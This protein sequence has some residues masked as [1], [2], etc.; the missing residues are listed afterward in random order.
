MNRYLSLLRPLIAV[1]ILAGLV[2]TV[3]FT[4]EKPVRYYW[5]DVAHVDSLRTILNQS[6]P[7]WMRLQERPKGSGHW[8]MQVNPVDTTAARLMALPEVEE[9]FPCPPNCR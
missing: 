6:G 9:S 3:A 2:L 8:W 5:Y 4:R 1:V 7:A